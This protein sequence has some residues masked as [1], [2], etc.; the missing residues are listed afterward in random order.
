MIRFNYLY[1][2]GGNYKRWGLLD[3]PNPERLSL[4]A[5][6]QRLVRCCEMGCLFIAHQVGVRELFLFNDGSIMSADHC[7]HEYDSVEE[8]EGALNL[9]ERT[10]AAFLRGFEQGAQEGWKAFDPLDRY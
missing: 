4:E 10:I 1:R 8:V 5:I 9:Q 2:D 7:Y 3:F 6:N